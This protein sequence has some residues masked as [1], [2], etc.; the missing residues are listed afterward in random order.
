MDL[1]HLL[2]YI[3]LRILDYGFGFWVWLGYGFGSLCVVRPYLIKE[4]I[5]RALILN[6]N[7]H[8]TL[9]KDKIQKKITTLK[10]ILN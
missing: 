7:I 1:G 8:H 5:K 4:F 10:E 6:L 3:G 2:R 9:K